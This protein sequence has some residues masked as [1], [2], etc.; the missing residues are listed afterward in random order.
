M[1]WPFML[2]ST[3]ETVVA[4]I[5]K[6]HEGQLQAVHVHFLGRLQELREDFQD[7]VDAEYHRARADGIGQVHRWAVEVNYNLFHGASPFNNMSGTQTMRARAALQDAEK[8]FDPT[9]TQLAEPKEITDG[10][11]TS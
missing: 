7:K 4:G 8:Q 3:H 6:H 11:V 5:K 10:A 9:R 2:K 1:R